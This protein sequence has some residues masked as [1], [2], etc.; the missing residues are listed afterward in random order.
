MTDD[1]QNISQ[2]IMDWLKNQPKWY[3]PVLKLI[4]SGRG[5]SDDDIKRLADM[6]LVAQKLSVQ[7]GDGV[8]LPDV[9]K[10]EVDA[11]CMAGREVKLHAIKNLKN[12]NRLR[13]GECL[14]F[15][16]K[17][18]TVI[19]GHNGSGKSG[20]S[21]ILRNV[22]YSRA[23]KPD[24]L[25]NVFASSGD[26]PS[27][28]IVAE[29]GG[30][31]TVEQWNSG[32]NADLLFPEVTVFDQESSGFEIR[33]NNEIVFLPRHL[34]L[35]KKLADYVAQVNNLLDSTIKQERSKIQF[36]AIPPSYSDDFEALRAG[37]KNLGDICFQKG[38]EE[39]L[40]D[41]QEQLASQPEARIPEL[42]RKKKQLTSIHDT[43][44]EYVHA[45]TREA[46][47]GYE[48]ALA[49]VEKARETVKN[50]TELARENACLDGF[51]S[52][53]WKALW[54][55]ARSYS[56]DLAY[57]DAKSHPHLDDGARCPLCQ[58]EYSDEARTR[59]MYFDEFMKGAANS[60]LEAAQKAQVELEEQCRTARDKIITQLPEA[61]LEAITD[62]KLKN[63]LKDFRSSVKGDGKFFD[64]DDVDFAENKLKNFVLSVLDE[65]VKEVKD[66][67]DKL[68]KRLNPDEKLTLENRQV[69][70]EKKRWFTD[71]QLAIEKGLQQE[72]LC[73]SLEKVRKSLR[74][75]DITN[76]SK[77]LTERDV[78]DRLDS[79]FD[80]EL[81][82]LFGANCPVS[83][84]K[85]GRKGESRT[86]LKIEGA[87]DGNV[88]PHQVFSEGEQ[89]VI[90]LAAFFANLTLQQRKSTVVFDDP[91]TSLDHLKRDKITHRIVCLSKEH[92][93]VVFT[94]DPFF[95]LSLQKIAEKSSLP[96]KALYVASRSQ[97]SGL[98]ETKSPF[99]A[100]K[101]KTRI[102]EL[103]QEELQELKRLER[104]ADPGF[105]DAIEH[106]YS[107]LRAL[108][109][110]VVEED[111]LNGVIIRGTP[112]VHTKQLAPVC[113]LTSS[114]IQVIEEI[115]T[116][117]SRIT[118]AHSNPASPPVEPP[119][120]KDF[121]DDLDSLTNLRTEINK[122][123]Q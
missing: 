63:L 84:A 35:L 9:T 108:C 34:E 50:A 12:V 17:G 59:M 21:R 45:C 91:V 51:A 116:K 85:S 103:R 20:Y 77:N 82:K 39:L 29:I 114:D 90:S 92:P 43:V 121:E 99:A 100:T 101:I 18:L 76:F 60:E 27:A 25:A 69:E 94:H 33:A 54:E 123:R 75:T 72:F 120:T 74:T 64:E 61:L 42:E 96:S 97:Y 19:Y 113:D 117:A 110:R 15:L 8:R 105:D 89:K 66:E 46:I 47:A 36:P 98:V 2:E 83:L 55:A 93:V 13:D 106:A 30:Q 86:A 79:A 87:V 65:E 102:G 4:V 88:K 81:Q 71:N 73:K 56:C 112:D 14:G 118:E 58:Q 24:I 52:D 3:L 111:L 122:R 107:V 49:R 26:S 7:L 57:P 37:T 41:I 95:A 38:D 40:K 5:I 6:V 70:L 16:P 104:D 53:E 28:D 67:I 1:Q 11:Y 62:T 22:C 119:K 78:H 80:D 32:S 68:N 115:M 44:H 23:N 109:E 10:Q 31:E 48:Q